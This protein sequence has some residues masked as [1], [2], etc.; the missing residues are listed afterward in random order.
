MWVSK[1]GTSHGPSGWI[2]TLCIELVVEL[3]LNDNVW[4]SLMV[5]TFLSLPMWFEHGIEGIM[6][7]TNQCESYH[8]CEVLFLVF[9]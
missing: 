2:L 4:G 5:F 7:N 1:T 8:E 6:C 3:D 9:Q